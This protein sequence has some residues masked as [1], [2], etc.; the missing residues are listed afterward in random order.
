MS[1]ST[2]FCSYDPSDNGTAVAG[3]KSTTIA[4]MSRQEPPEKPN[5]VKNLPDFDFLFATQGAAKMIECKIFSI[6][7]L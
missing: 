2:P 7:F 5:L 1:M 4:A 6:V 3:M